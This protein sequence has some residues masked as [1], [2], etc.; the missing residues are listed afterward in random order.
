MEIALAV[1]RSGKTLIPVPDFLPKAARVAIMATARTRV[2]I[3]VG[4]GRIDPSR[5]DYEALMRVPASRLD[6]D[7]RMC[8]ASSGTEGRPRLYVHQWSHLSR[9]LSALDLVDWG[10]APGGRVVN[11]A[12]FA[13]GA[14]IFQGI[15]ALHHGTDMVVDLER[16]NS[17]RTA[18]LI[19][20]H[21]ARSLVANPR[22]IAGLP[23]EDLGD[24]EVVLSSTNTLPLVTQQEFLSAHP[25]RTLVNIY[26]C[27]EGGIVSSK[28]IT[29]PTECIGAP[30]PAANVQIHNQEDGVGEVVIQGDSCAVGEFSWRG[31][32]SWTAAH[33]GDLACL[34]DNG[35]MWL[36]GRRSDKV[37]TS[38]YT[39]YTT[40]IERA[41]LEIEG[42]SEAAVIGVSDPDKGQELVGFYV[43]SASAE[44][45][46]EGLRLRVPF[47]AIP[48][49]LNRIEELPMSPAGKVVKRS[50]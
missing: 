34:D 46:I 25:N 26:S 6:G 28:T 32:T 20:E 4:T 35:E 45:L 19:R 16:P 2:R 37:V 21:G 38:G 49:A 11:N 14:G 27:T 47:Y 48:R 31:F 13:V 39:V 23:G 9:Y 29:E 36:R 43:G 22:T 44:T 33:T 40:Q 41:L 50:L 7:G 18:E 10:Y 17:G 8:F 5:D 30:Y 3:G 15:I 1:L 42:V 24:L 12:P